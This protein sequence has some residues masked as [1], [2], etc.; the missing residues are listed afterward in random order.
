[1]DN[2]MTI[3]RQEIEKYAGDAENGYSY[4]AEDPEHNLFTQYP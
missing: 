4:L 1:M 2:L 3:L